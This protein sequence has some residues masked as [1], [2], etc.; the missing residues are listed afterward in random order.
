VETGAGKGEDRRFCDDVA[1]TGGIREGR[2]K[3]MD[4]RNILKVRKQH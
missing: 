3:W 2:G 1:E 4:S